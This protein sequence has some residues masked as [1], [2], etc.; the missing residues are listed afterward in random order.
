MAGD[1]KE[2]CLMIIRDASRAVFGCYTTESWRPETCCYGGGECMVFKIEPTFQCY[3][4]TSEKQRKPI[5]MTSTEDYVMVGGGHTASVDATGAAAIYFDAEL[6]Q[7]ASN[8]SDTFANDCLA[9]SNDFKI[10]GLE[11]WQF[12][13]TE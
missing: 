2:P 9:S 4:W 13:S 12:V 6:L 5:F 1:V 3:R 10:D 11:I 7:G 8:C